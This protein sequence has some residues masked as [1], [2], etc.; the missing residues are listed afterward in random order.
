ML[1][2]ERL[3]VPAY[4]WALAGVAAFAGLLAFGFYLGPLWG[5]GVAVGVL[6]VLI[7]VF[8][9]AAVSIVVDATTLRVGRSVIELD[10]LGEVTDLDAEQTTRRAGVEADARA[11]L[12]LRPYVPT[13]VQVVLVDPDDPVPYWLISSRH[14]YE[15][16]AALE[17]VLRQHSAGAQP[18][19]G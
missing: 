6:G 8:V 10:Y 11:H 14:P 18:P 1:F 2:R 4:W 16:A 3:T 19:L 9:S 17:A 15:L 12:V 5:I 7:A 13:A